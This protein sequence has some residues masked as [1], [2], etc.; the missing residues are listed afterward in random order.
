M[1]DDDPQDQ[2]IFLT[3]RHCL[4]DLLDGLISPCVCGRSKN[5][6]AISDYLQLYT[7]LDKSCSSSSF[8]V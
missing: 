2:E 7:P 1:Q 6:W 8:S 3:E 4:A 5:V